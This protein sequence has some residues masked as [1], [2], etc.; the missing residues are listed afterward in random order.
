[1]HWVHFRFAFQVSYCL[2]IVQVMCSWNVRFPNQFIKRF[3]PFLFKI[4]DLY[5]L[6]H[7]LFFPFLKHRL[8]SALGKLG[9]LKMSE[10]LLSPT[11]CPSLLLT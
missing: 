8:V 9:S 4:I 2:E 1:M 7:I 5:I 6:G 3:S 11:G 10:Y